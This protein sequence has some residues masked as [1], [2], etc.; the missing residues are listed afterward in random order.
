[1]ADANK[2]M[3]VSRCPFHPRNVDHR[4]GRLPISVSGCNNNSHR[5]PAGVH[6]MPNWSGS[7][8]RVVPCPVSLCGFGTASCASGYSKNFLARRPLESRPRLSHRAPPPPKQPQ[9]PQQPLPRP[10]IVAC[11]S[12]NPSLTWKNKRPHNRWFGEKKIVNGIHTS[13]QMK[14]PRVGQRPDRDFL[15]VYVNLMHVR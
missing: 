3:S 8:S 15:I 9:Q 2:K 14:P 5:Y 11:T 1:M 7:T 10:R 12:L 13:I 6:K 4:V